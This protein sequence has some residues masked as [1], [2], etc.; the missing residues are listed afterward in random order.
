MSEHVTI[1]WL[2]QDLRLSDN[3]A[4]AWAAER[5]RVVA[6]YIHD[7]A[8]GRPLGGAS[9]WW[10]QQSLKDLGGRIPLVERVGEY[11]QVLRELIEE[12][13]AD[14]VVWN[15]CYEPWAVHRDTDLKALLKDEVGVEV[16][17]FNA[18]LL[19]EPW[20]VKT[21]GG[22]EFKVFTPFWKACLQK[23]VQAPCPVPSKID[24]VKGLKSEAVTLYPLKGE[25]QWAAGWEKLWTPGEDG[26]QAA[27][28]AFFAGKVK[29]YSEGRDIPAK[30]GTSKLSP[31]LHFG[32]I[33]PRQVW[34]A[35]QKD[36]SADADKFLSEVGWREF[37]H[38]LLF[39]YPTMVDTNWKRAFDAYPWRE[40][41]GEAAKDFEAWKLGKTGY[42]LVDAGMRQ[43]WQTGWMHNRVRMVV[44]SFLI[45]HLRID[46]REGETWFWETLVDADAANNA[47]GWQWVAGS[48][49]DASPY[50]RIFNPTSQAEKFDGQNAYIKRWVPEYGTKDYP[51]PIVNH[52]AARKAAMDGYAKVKS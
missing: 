16:Q 21:L 52:E 15:R 28:K 35:A 38:H 17:S 47:C 44:A 4:L 24:W 12:T 51:K 13:K 3:P 37:S 6:V 46:W 9:K 36:G 30:D 33:G 7:E 14:A 19:F 25:P 22:T 39:H 41:T 1:W 8:N 20:E 50:F 5:G 18:A 48:G 11:Q 49:A 45:K 43:L 42:P 32:E 10:L 40:L 31:H 34:V 27:L 26:A 23:E 2:R 29:G